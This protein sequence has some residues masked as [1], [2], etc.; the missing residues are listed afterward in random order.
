MPEYDSWEQIAGY[1]D[2]DGTIVIFDLSNVPYKLGL[3]LI[4]VDRS[5]DQIKMVRGFLQKEGIR[6]SNVLR[7]NKRSNAWIVA[8]G[9]VDS[10]KACLRLMLPHLSKKAVEAQAAFDYYE[11]KI[12]RNNL[13]AV[14][15]QE[16]EAGRRERHPRRVLI[17]VPY[18]YPAGDKALKGLRTPKLRDG[19]GRYKTK[20]S[21]EDFQRIREA[22][23]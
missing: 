15:Q 6:T 4:F 3:S 18:A 5:T 16:V 2:A 11:A 12:T 21:V 1:F 9:A 19:L 23:F 20:V 13:V 7:S 22:H 8:I 17:D 10:V 14:L